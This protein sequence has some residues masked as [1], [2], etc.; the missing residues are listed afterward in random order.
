MEVVQN[1]RSVEGNKMTEEVLGKLAQLLGQ[2]QFELVLPEEWKISPGIWSG[3]GKQK[4]EI[5][6]VYLMND[7][8]E[9]FLVLQNAG[10]TG[11]Y[12]DDYEGELEANLSFRDGRYVLVVKQ[13]DTVMTLFFEDMD[14][15]VELYD[16]VH[17]GHFWVHGYEYLR[18]LEYRLAILR[19][20][21]DYLGETS[22]TDEEKELAV[23]TEFPPLNYCCYPAVS[24]KYIIGKNEPWKPSEKAI[25]FMKKLACE[26]GDGKFAKILDLY[27]K[28]PVRL[29]AKGLAVMLHH[30]RHKEV[31]N[32]LMQ[33]MEEAAGGY[34]RRF[35]GE[36][37]ETLYL[38]I[39][40]KAEKRRQ[41]LEKQG[42]KA[43]ILREEPFTTARD[44]LEYKVYLM[45]WKE[46]GGNIITEI[47][48]YSCADGR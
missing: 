42:I 1:G 47:E 3:E 25:K 14:L 39:Y 18:Q 4:R 16:Y 21:Y 15:E 23:L 13:K 24:D 30:V 8:I 12:R 45:I 32:L 31:V 28:Y 48:E 26:C 29:I 27:E 34:K 5:K 6:I 19:D 36:E 37:M 44:S 33:K 17:T 46:K 7:A 11:L 2:D 22:C 41:E 43:E 38:R 20:K 35:L 10:M 40:E 9:S